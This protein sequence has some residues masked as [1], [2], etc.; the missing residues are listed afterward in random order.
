MSKYTKEEVIDLQIVSNFL[1]QLDGKQTIPAVTKGILLDIRS[2]T[3]KIS[4]NTAKVISEKSE[5]FSKEVKELYKEYK[6]TSKEGKELLLKDKLIIFKVLSYDIPDFKD[7]VGTMN[8]YSSKLNAITSDYKDTFDEISKLLESE[9]EL[10]IPLIPLEDLPDN[11][12]YDII[13][14]IRKIYRRKDNG[15]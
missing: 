6:Q 2:D 10:N 12:P 5:D 3:D 11:V 1:I 15:K 7:D 9:V 13:D 4:K 8:E 14:I